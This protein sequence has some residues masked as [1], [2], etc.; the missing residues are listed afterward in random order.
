M[1][2]QVGAY[3]CVFRCIAGRAVA[4]AQRDL[5]RVTRV[6]LHAEQKIRGQ[7]RALQRQHSECPGPA[8]CARAWK[9]I[10]D[11]RAV[12][13]APIWYSAAGEQYAT[14]A[15]EIL[16]QALRVLAAIAHL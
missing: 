1:L 14:H 7:T 5:A 15:R 16:A 4:V 10:R 8:A 13:P 6:L 9:I 12:G 11:R 3:R 2:A